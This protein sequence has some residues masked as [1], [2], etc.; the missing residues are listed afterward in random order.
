M[1]LKSHWERVF[2]TKGPEA[3]SWTQASPDVSLRLLGQAGLAPGDR[4]LDVGA[5]LGDLPM[6]LRE[7]G[8][9]VTLVDL[10]GE[11]LR[12]ARARLGEAAEVMEWIEGDITRVELEPGAFDLWHDRAVFHF[13]TEEAD[14]DRYRTQLLRA[15]RLGGAVILATFAPEG[16]E[17]CSGLPVRRHAPEDLA[18]FLG[19]EFRLRAS[20]RQ[21]H[22]T[23]MGSTQAFTWTLFRRG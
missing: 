8:L 16:P 13:L 9:R 14:R 19:P 21:V 12:R 1:D 23:P 2:E 17:R 10:S 11:A 5:G 7:T 4:L 6:A 22:P 20:E 15:L 3:M 18:A